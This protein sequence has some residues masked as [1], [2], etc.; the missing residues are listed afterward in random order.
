[1]LINYKNLLTHKNKTTSIPTCWNSTSG[2]FHGVAP[3]SLLH[4]LRACPSLPSGWAV[5]TDKED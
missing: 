4:S 3:L 5:H 1:M 2:L